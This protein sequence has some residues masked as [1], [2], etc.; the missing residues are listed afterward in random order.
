[1]RLCGPPPRNQR[2]Q[3]NP[4]TVHIALIRQLPA[5][6]VLGRKIAPRADNACRKAKGRTVSQLHEAQADS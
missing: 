3:H 2:Q 1:M 4:E 5:R 6:R